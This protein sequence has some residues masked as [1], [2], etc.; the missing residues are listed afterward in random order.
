MKAG[1][2]AATAA[3]TATTQLA[4]S[5]ESTPWAQDGPVV[6]PDVAAPRSQSTSVPTAAGV[7]AA[8]EYKMPP[9]VAEKPEVVSQV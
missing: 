4:A 8:H 5:A 6:T 1:T 7:P 2:G 3:A 9:A